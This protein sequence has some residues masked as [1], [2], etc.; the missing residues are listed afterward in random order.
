MNQ[1]L[2][3]W[4][5][6]VGLFCTMILWHFH[7]LFAG[8]LDN[9]LWGISISADPV[10]NLVEASDWIQSWRQGCV[11]H[12]YM[13]SV[14]FGSVGPPELW[15]WL[16]PGWDI[17]LGLAVLTG[18]LVASM[19]LAIICLFALNYF[20][21]LWCA[22]RLCKDPAVA[23]MAAVLITFNAY[24]YAH[25]WAHLGLIPIFY[26]PAFIYAFARLYETTRYRYGV[27][28]AII[29]GL[30]LYTSPYYA[31]FMLWVAVALFLGYTLA[32][33]R[34]TWRHLANIALMIFLAA[35]IALPYLQETYMQDYSPYWKQSWGEMQY[36]GVEWLNSFS[37]HPSDYILPFVH[38]ALYGDFFQPFLTAPLRMRHVWSDE[39]PIF[40][41]F[42]PLLFIVVGIY[43]MVGVLVKKTDRTKSC[44]YPAEA[45]F[46]A[47][48]LQN[49][50]LLFGL[51]A[52]ATVAF[53]IS[54][55][56]SVELFGLHLSMPNEYLRHIVPFRA[57]S[58]LAIVV[59]V[60]VAL[61]MALVADQSRRPKVWAW[62]A[63]MIAAF[64]S[65]PATLLHHASRETAYIKYLR[66]RPERVIMR[67]EAQNVRH[68]RAIDLE[69]ILAEKDTLNGEVNAN[70]GYS[71]L[72]LNSATS[73][74]N[75]GHLAAMGAELLIVDGQLTLPLKDQPYA[76]ILVYF[77]ED[78]IQ[79]IKLSTDPD[80]RLRHLFE[81]YLEARRADRC[82]VAEKPKVME[83]LKAYY[84]LL[85]EAN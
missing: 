11:H 43:C 72:A 83:T 8:A 53:F 15:R 74:F 65:W 5:I 67:F 19:N 48:R 21:T 30:S 31:Y 55:V 50:G 28:S 71:D 54:L 73:K 85:S 24:S 41:G 59:L 29:A 68:K 79:I 23:L 56:P 76:K 62:L 27:I 44:T 10:G 7:G 75:L 69:A 1:G 40:L 78:N 51:I 57:Y 47:A 12:W 42:G 25:S 14:P 84:Q 80:P 39:L 3:W 20:V 81:P 60:A 17:F 18:N 35:L 36:S 52:L 63:I 38:H 66:D 77:P 2:K 26:F 13:H 22:R 6:S 49:R 45:T 61:L 70:Y 64:D 9:S 4:L 34:W 33:R 32:H 82:F 58:R 16:V 37:A 46:R